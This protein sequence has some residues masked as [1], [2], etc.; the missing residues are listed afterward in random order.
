M[1]AKLK[2]LEPKHHNAIRMKVEGRDHAEIAQALGFRKPTVNNWF[3]DPMVKAEVDA[4]QQRV[5]DLF[6]EKMASA[7]LKT[8]D[9]MTEMLEMPI[10]S[11]YN[12]D[13]EP[14]E[15]QYLTF[16]ER[17]QIVDRFLERSEHTQKPQPFGEGNGEAAGLPPA[18]Q[19]QLNMFSSMQPGELIEALAAIIGQKELPKAIESK[20]P[21]EAKAK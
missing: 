10:S 11:T 1:P 17:M 9:V 12:E 8:L 7:G 16:A 3:S 2:K 18:I 21:K 14:V 6:E 20:P 13:G 19:A 5:G 4:V 15:R